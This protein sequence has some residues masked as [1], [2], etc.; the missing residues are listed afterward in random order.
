MVVSQKVF[1]SF[2]SD[3]GDSAG[4]VAVKEGGVEGT[5]RFSSCRTLL[6]LT[7]RTHVARRVPRTPAALTL[8]FHLC[9][10]ATR[11]DLEPEEVMEDRH[12]ATRTPKPLGRKLAPRSRV[13]SSGHRHYRQVLHRCSC[14]AQ[15]LIIPVNSLVP[16]MAELMRRT[17]DAATN[18]TGRGPE[19]TVQN[20]KRLILCPFDV[21]SGSGDKSKIHVRFT[22]EQIDQTGEW[23]FQ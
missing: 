2:G 8:L 15:R 9:H 3:A 19:I 6:R 7:P 17:Q 1:L 11:Q 22:R 14:D 23:Q 10:C 20:S 18:H 4:N 13:R 16:A 5:G 12:L 21:V